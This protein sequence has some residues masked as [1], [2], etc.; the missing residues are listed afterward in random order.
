MSFVFTVDILTTISP[1]K[2]HRGKG[3]KAR[4][5]GELMEDFAIF[6]VGQYPTQMRVHRIFHP[7]D[8]RKLF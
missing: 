4:E 2:G 1:F 3:K 8:F 5:G 6:I 7:I